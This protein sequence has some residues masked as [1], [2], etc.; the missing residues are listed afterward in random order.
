MSRAYE[1]YRGTFA[2][3]DGRMCQAVLRGN[4]YSA[5]WEEPGSFE[6]AEEDPITIIDIDGVEVDES[7]QDREYVVNGHTVNVAEL[8]M[9]W[10]LIHGEYADDREW[11]PAPEWDK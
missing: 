7:E 9:D 10:L 4:N 1:S 3:P 2:L 6:V 11:E 5:T 8:C